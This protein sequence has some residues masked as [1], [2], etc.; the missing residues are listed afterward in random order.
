MIKIAAHFVMRGAFATSMADEQIVGTMVISANVF[1]PD[2]IKTS[3]MVSLHVVMVVL[4]MHVSKVVCMVAAI[5][6]YMH[7]VLPCRSSPRNG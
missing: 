6:I 3:S 2:T 7:E 4:Q 5:L 1:A